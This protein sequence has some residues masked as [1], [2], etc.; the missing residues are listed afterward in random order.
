MPLALVGHYMVS[1]DLGLVKTCF[2]VFVLLRRCSKSRSRLSN[3]VPWEVVTEGATPKDP[4]VVEQAM[5][6]VE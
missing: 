4:A 6:L 3:I 5:A 2:K 1:R